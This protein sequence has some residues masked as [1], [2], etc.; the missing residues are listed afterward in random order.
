MG[1]KQTIETLEKIKGFISCR[2]SMAMP[3][4]A[5]VL[6]GSWVKAVESAIGILQSMEEGAE[7][8]RE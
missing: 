5:S 8:G 3:G 2:M 6:L 7:E 4:E 1:V